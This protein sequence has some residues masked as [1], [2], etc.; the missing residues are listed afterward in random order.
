MSDFKFD[1]WETTSIC[2]I[3]SII[4]LLNQLKYKYSKVEAV[5]Y[6]KFICKKL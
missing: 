6:P 4:I 5:A 2:E 1:E 3:I